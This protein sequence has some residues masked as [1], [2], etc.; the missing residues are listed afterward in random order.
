[1]LVFFFSMQFRCLCTQKHQCITFSH[2]TPELPHVGDHSDYRP[3]LV[4]KTVSG[5]WSWNMMS[6]VLFSPFWLANMV[7]FTPKVEEVIEKFHTFTANTLWDGNPPLFSRLYLLLCSLLAK[8]RPCLVWNQRKNV[9]M[10]ICCFRRVG[11]SAY[12]WT[13]PEF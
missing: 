9:I 11:K 4:R 5:D 10:A 12:V 3:L 6:C 8:K 2:F 13:W 1:M 7:G